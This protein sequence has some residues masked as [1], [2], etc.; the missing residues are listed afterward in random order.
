MSSRDP[1]PFAEHGEPTLVGDPSPSGR[2]AAVTV[3]QDRP[4]DQRALPVA[5]GRYPILRELGQGGMGHVYVG[6]DEELNREI[7]VKVV[8]A[9][10]MTARNRARLR[11]EAQALAQL[12]HPN[13]VPVFEVGEHEGETYLVMELVVGVSIRRWLRNDV[14]SWQQ[15]L[16][17]F[18]QAGRGL[19]AAHARGLVHRDFKPENALVGDDPHA[20]GVGRVRVVDFGL[21]LEGDASDDEGEPESVLHTEPALRTETGEVL[22][23][24]GYMAPEQL[25]RRTIGAAA[26][27]FALAV[28]LFEALTRMRPFAGSS[29][30]EI[31]SA[32]LA[33]VPLPLPTGP[34]PAALAP[35]L[36]RGLAREP[37]DRW[38]SMAAMIDALEAIRTRPADNSR[39]RIT[40]AVWGT[41]TVLAAGA[42]W[43]LHEPETPAVTTVAPEANTPLADTTPTQPSEAPE[44]PAAAQLRGPPSDEQTR[45]RV[46][47]AEAVAAQ[48]R[49]EHDNAARRFAAAAV[50]YERS[51][52]TGEDLARIELERALAH[53]SAFIVGGAELD[54]VIAF[55]LL[56]RSSYNHYGHPRPREVVVP[57][58]TA[59]HELRA[60]PQR[61]TPPDVML[62]LSQRWHLAFLDVHP[63]GTEVY[64]FDELV[65]RE[66]CTVPTKMGDGA[67]YRFR[68]EGFFE[69][70]S[71]IN[72]P[73][74]DWAF[75]PVPL[76]RLAPGEQAEPVVLP[77]P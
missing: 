21:V 22:G 42:W 53:R 36:R 24:P 61:V 25:E 14:R 29:A 45:A 34:Y 37:G 59:L 62:D 46:P 41:A 43:R 23:T 13:V 77:K 40:F 67:V 52:S 66:P 50:F 20:H 57:A 70:I 69:A 54:L 11:R 76:V 7:A 68:R 32:V 33:G 5:I 63:P 48:S 18:I 72:P 28:S 6:F 74:L 27:Q 30:Q 1:P 8:R 10:R 35:V 4:Q 56:V 64:R 51:W 49:G 16:D 73:Y 65:C 12:A 71:M 39:R 19:A 2:A 55:E 17:V 60:R 9:E 75:N 3:R 44:E 15:I 38:P 58:I 26:D 31:A 47:F